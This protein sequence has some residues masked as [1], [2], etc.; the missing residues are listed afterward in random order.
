MAFTT[1]ET[2]KSLPIDATAVRHDNLQNA[3]TER[4]EPN[5]YTKM[6]AQI[7]EN[8]RQ[9]KEIMTS[10]IASLGDSG[11]KHLVVAGFAS[12]WDNQ[13]T[14]PLYA[15]IISPEKSNLT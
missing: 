13:D 11:V 12:H 2:D 6:M 10:I 1:P 14:H 15:A 3:R 4:L 9:V 5:E 7:D 8:S